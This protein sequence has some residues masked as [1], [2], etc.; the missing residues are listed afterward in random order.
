[1]G[2]HVLPLYGCRHSSPM[3]SGILGVSFTIVINNHHC[4]IANR[5]ITEKNKTCFREFVIFV[6]RHSFVLHYF[7]NNE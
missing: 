2:Q 3:L 1:M 7:Y 5:Q 4:R 6:N